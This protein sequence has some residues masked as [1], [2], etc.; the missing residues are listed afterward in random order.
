MV[1]VYMTLD[2]W[3]TGDSKPSL[4]GNQD[5]RQFLAVWLAA[6]HDPLGPRVIP[7]QAV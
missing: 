4:F 5:A 6:T 1:V 7:F 3:S 2:S